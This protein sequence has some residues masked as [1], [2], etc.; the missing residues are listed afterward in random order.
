[1]VSRPGFNPAH[2]ARGIKGE[3]WKKIIMDSRHPLQ[4]KAI[5]GQYPPGSTFK[6]VTAL[7]ALQ[8][9]IANTE[10]VVY[11]PGSFTMGNRRFRC[12]KRGGHGWTDMRKAL[13]E[14]CDVYFYK[15]GYELGID[16]LSETAVSLGLG[17]RTGIDL[18]GEKKG[19]M[20]DRDWKWRRF[21]E[22]WYDGE[23]VNASIGQ[24]FVLATPIQLAVMTAAVANNGKVM[25]PYV[26]SRVEHWSGEKLLENVPTVVNKIGLDSKHLH[27][28]FKGLEAAVNE[29]KGTAWTSRLEKIRIAGKTGTAQVVKLK[30]KLDKN[31][32]EEDIPYNLR[33]HALFVACAP[34][35][36]P[37]IAVAVVVEH[38]SHGG[39]VAA[40]ITQAIFS[41]YFGVEV[42]EKETL[43]GG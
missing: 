36:K 9:G 26:V 27:A 40:P 3:E 41:H 30:E 5:K 11:C 31:K 28:V 25:K 2:F 29:R 12:W 16:I 19:L 21:G 23:T 34:A 6:I 1:M 39:S 35:E 43:P 22:K 7:S 32:D 4:N 24:G 15:V 8:A 42:P 20:P 37:E 17:D 14:S 33:D 18:D 13:K 38:G 10:T